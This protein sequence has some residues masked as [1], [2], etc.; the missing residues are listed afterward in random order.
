MTRPNGSSP[1]SSSRIAAVVQPD[2]LAEA[3]LRDQLI[4][5]F[6]TV[7]LQ[8]NRDEL[9]GWSYERRQRGAPAERNPQLDEVLTLE[10][11][12]HLQVPLDPAGIL[13]D[14]EEPTAGPLEP[15]TKLNVADAEVWSRARDPRAIFTIRV[16]LR[17]DPGERT[18]FGAAAVAWDSGNLASPL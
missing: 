16:G 18:A 7:C 8:V 12:D 13:L 9:A 6:N 2:A 17:I 3:A 14:R 10:A 5:G 1:N 11:L 4:E 15:T